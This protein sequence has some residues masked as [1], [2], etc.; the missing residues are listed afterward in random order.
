MAPIDGTRTGGSNHWF[1]TT[2]WSEIRQLRQS[3]ESLHHK[4]LESLLTKYWTP[5]FWY[6]RKQGYTHDKAKDITQDF[7]HEVVLGRKLFEN[8]WQDKGRLRSFLLIAVKRYLIST[9]RKQFAQKRNP[10]NYL[11]SLDRIDL[12]EPATEDNPDQ[13]F[14]HAWAAE[15]LDKTLEALC[16]MHTHADKQIQ[17]ALF[18][19]RILN[20]AFKNTKPPTFQELCK[21][22]NIETETKASNMVTT[23][24]RRFQ[25]TLRKYLRESV[26]SD[27]D[28]DDEL[29]ALVRI[30]SQSGA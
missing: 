20:P 15:L 21:K 14:A 18:C 10:E 7:F 26:G 2:Q 29:M 11:I 25:S 19:E 17:W 27:E 28:V 4:L 9:K 23:V 1:Q 5:V 6:I 16:E 3:E 24:K 13:A 8:A 12:P 22:Y 30:F